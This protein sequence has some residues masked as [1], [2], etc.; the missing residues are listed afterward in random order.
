MNRACRSTCWKTAWRGRADGAGRVAA[1]DG[2]A[3]TPRKNSKPAGRSSEERAAGLPCLAASTGWGARLPNRP[4]RSHRH[5]G[6]GRLPRNMSLTWTPDDGVSKSF[7]NRCRFP[8]RSR[9]TGHDCRHCGGKAAWRKCREGAALPRKSPQAGQ[10]PACGEGLIRSG[11]RWSAGARSVCSK[12]GARGS[13]LCNRLR[14]RPGESLGSAAVAAF[15]RHRGHR[16]GSG[17]KHGFH[18]AAFGLHR[19]SFPVVFRPAFCSDVGNTIAP[20]CGT[21]MA[22]RNSPAGAV[23]GELWQGAGHI[24]RSGASPAAAKA[25][26]VANAGQSLPGFRRISGR[27]GRVD[28]DARAQRRITEISRP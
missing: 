24:P 6:P 14:R 13:R 2:T 5:P 23:R 3:T 4:R 26:A 7:L 11:G 10:C 8:T 16:P 22:R 17:G 15:P 21:V 28:A 9:A 12:R 25:A 18:P 1:A 19:A 27:G 20:Q